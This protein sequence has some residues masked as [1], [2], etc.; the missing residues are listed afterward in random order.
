[1]SKDIAA[2]FEKEINFG[3]MSQSIGFYD[4]VEQAIAASHDGDSHRA[5]NVFLYALSAHVA[6]KSTEWVDSIRKKL[7]NGVSITNLEYRPIMRKDYSGGTYPYVDGIE[8]ELAIGDFFGIGITSPF[9]NTK[10]RAGFLQVN[11]S[12]ADMVRQD[13]V[14]E[15]YEVVKP[16]K[17]GVIKWKNV[18]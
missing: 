9:A 11:E 17:K 3:I 8:V 2:V 10:I 13:H 6:W 1:M 4:T 15:I 7:P 18:K 14:Y 12:G 16:N 5:A